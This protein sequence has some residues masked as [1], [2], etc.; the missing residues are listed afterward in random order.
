MGQNT[1][2]SYK[3][4]GSYAFYVPRGGYADLQDIKG[5]IYNVLNIIEVYIVRFP[6]NVLAISR[7]FIL[8][9][10]QTF[11]EYLLIVYF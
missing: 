5:R 1:K 9:L 7:P 11:C 3:R 4:S 6:V 2:K 10:N 8:K